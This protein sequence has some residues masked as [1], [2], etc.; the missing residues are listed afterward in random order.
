MYSPLTYLMMFDV[1]GCYFPKW[2]TNQVLRIY[3]ISLL[4]IRLIITMLNM[5]ELTQEAPAEQ[6]VSAGK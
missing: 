6:T 1:T 4:Q 3:T 5:C 2:Y